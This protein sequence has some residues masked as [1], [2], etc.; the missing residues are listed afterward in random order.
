MFLGTITTTVEGTA[1]DR[2]T[3]NILLIPNSLTKTDK[4]IAINTSKTVLLLIY[5][6]FEHSCLNQRYS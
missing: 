1:R 3:T 6:N 2:I 4:K 5:L